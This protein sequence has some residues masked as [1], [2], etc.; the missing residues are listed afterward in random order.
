MSTI[1]ITCILI[2]IL[3]I[4]MYVYYSKLDITG[5]RNRNS[6]KNNNAERFTEQELF[7]SKQLFD[8]TSGRIKFTEFKN[9]LNVDIVDFNDMKKIWAFNN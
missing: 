5:F 6:F 1:I 3:L 2:C 4:L 8:N 9:N 7:I